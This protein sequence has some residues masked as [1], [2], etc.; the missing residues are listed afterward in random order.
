MD[1]IFYTFDL[2]PHSQPAKDVS[3]IEKEKRLNESILIQKGEN[4]ETPSEFRLGE[5]V[6]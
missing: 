1:V 3:L 2:P 4:I 5:G 6:L